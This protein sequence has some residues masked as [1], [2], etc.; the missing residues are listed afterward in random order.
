MDYKK[1]ILVIFSS[2]I[3]IKFSHALDYRSL[4]EVTT[5]A[6]LR[7]GPGRWYPVKWVIKNPSLPI[8]V[9]EENDGFLLAELHDGKKYWIY[10]DLTHRKHNLIVTKDTVIKNNK[11]KVIA[12]VL[13]DVIIKEH[14]CSEK[15]D[16][17]LCKVKINNVKGFIYKNSLWGYN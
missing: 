16:S 17:N 8:K 1:I 15:K 10:K 13:K 6:N 11:G 4:K 14:S 5:K 7:A 9:I 3:L 2:L 12:K